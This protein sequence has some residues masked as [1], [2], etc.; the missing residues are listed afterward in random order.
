MAISEARN[1]ANKKWDAKNLDRIQLVVRAGEREQIRSAAEAAGE[2]LNH[3]IVAATKA[4]MKAEGRKIRQLT[5]KD[6]SIE[7]ARKA[8][9]GCNAVLNVFRTAAHEQTNSETD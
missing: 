6:M 9:E 1:K 8:E 7:E 2:S 4:R 5:I 3:Y